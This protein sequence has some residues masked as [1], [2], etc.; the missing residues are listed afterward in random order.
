[1]DQDELA[2]KIAQARDE[3]WTTLDLAGSELDPSEDEIDEDEIVYLP[4]EIGN[5]TSLTELF[6][7]GNDLTALPPEIGNL[8][9]L[10]RLALDGNELTALPPEIGN[11]TGLKLTIP[12][13]QA[14]EERWL[15]R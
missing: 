1:M 4:P 6:L 15:P 10:T 3:G 7:D 12:I 13:D 9:G 14:D 5:L 11:L 2:K 8:T